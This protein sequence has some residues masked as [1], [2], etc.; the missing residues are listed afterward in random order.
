MKRNCS[1]QGLAD[2]ARALVERLSSYSLSLACAESCSGGIASAALTNVPG[3]SEVF[4]GGFVAYSNDC[5]TR[6]LGVSRATLARS[7]AV[8]REA[9]REMASGALTS[10]GADLAFATTGLAGPGGGTADKPVGGVWIAWATASGLTSEIFEVFEGDRDAIRLAA[11]I[12]AIEGA[13]ELATSLAAP[14]DLV[15]A[16]NADIDN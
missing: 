10:S 8:S 7:G 3:A 5:K 14:S 13:F 16:E 9:A 12:R 15:P 6:I 1:A 2:A 4:W 11:A